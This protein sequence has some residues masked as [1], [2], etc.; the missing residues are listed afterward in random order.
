MNAGQR[1]INLDFINGYFDHVHILIALKSV[2]RISDIVH[3]IK[4]ESSHWINKTGLTD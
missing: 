1:G 2:Q 4:G 3:D